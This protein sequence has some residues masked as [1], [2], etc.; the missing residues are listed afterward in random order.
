MLDEVASPGMLSA[1]LDGR[2][3]SE[4]RRPKTDISASGKDKTQEVHAGCKDNG[5]K[6]ASTQTSG[7]LGSHTGGTD[8]AMYEALNVKQ[9]CNIGQ[10]KLEKAETW[11]PEEGC[12]EFLEELLVSLQWGREQTY[13]PSAQPHSTAELAVT[14]HKLA[15]AVHSHLLGN[16]GV[17]SQKKIPSPVEFCSTPAEKMAEKVLR[18]LDPVTCTE[19]SA[20]SPFAESS[21]TTLLAVKKNIGR[22][23]PYTRYENIT[24]NCCNHCQGELIAL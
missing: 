10:R 20:D 11:T 12:K 14:N 16:V 9:R 23:H 1:E 24:F 22:F 18:I 19:S 13:C 21:T 3:W 17:S 7:G 4:L 8:W 6:K 2:F 15:K 5:I